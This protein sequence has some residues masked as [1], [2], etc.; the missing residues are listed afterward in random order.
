MNEA[1]NL[2]EHI[3]ILCANY[4]RS[5]GREL[6]TPGTDPVDIVRRLAVAPFA[7]VSHGIQ[8]DPIFNYGN[9]IALELFEMTWNEFTSLPSRLSAEMIDQFERSRLLD[10]VSKQG[11]IDN[12]SGI[13][14]SKSGRRFMIKDA[15]VW[16]LIDAE[17]KYYGQAALIGSWDKSP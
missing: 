9:N 8:D 15:T 5:T 4:L 1:A 14:I 7:V 17:G 2:V 16:N 13:R 10:Q 11:Y 12:Y 6:I 3:E